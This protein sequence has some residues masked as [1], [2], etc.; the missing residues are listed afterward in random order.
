[1]FRRN[2]VKKITL[3]EKNTQKNHIKIKTLINEA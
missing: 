2:H 1:M 3:F